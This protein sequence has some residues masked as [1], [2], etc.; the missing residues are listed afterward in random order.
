MWSDFFFLKSAILALYDYTVRLVLFSAAYQE[1]TH[2]DT[3]FFSL[4]AEE[5]S[6]LTASSE[7][8]PR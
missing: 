3:G 4:R 1:Q 6:V 2:A 7:F 5:R 8:L